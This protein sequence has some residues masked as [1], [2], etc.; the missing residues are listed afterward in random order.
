MTEVK[1][2]PGSVEE[3]LL[4][5]TNKSEKKLKG[6]QPPKKKMSGNQKQISL[7]LTISQANKNFGI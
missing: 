6:P 4:L 5:A 2:S 3:K 7:R 1:N